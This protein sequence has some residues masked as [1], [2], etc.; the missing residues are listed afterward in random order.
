[1]DFL[2]YFLFKLIIQSTIIKK[3]EKNYNIYFPDLP[4]CIASGEDI[5]Q[6]VNQAKGAL[7]LH[8]WGMEQDDEVIPVPEYRDMHIAANETICFIDVNM[9]GIRAKM[10]NRSV[11]KTLS[12]PWYL[13]EL[14]EKKKIN[15]SQLLQSALRAQ[16][17]L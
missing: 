17:G 8:L 14:A 5:P 9:F 3:N 2:F 6:A 4:G 15:F 12:I 7:E 16:L 11:K 10:D 13:N 1:M